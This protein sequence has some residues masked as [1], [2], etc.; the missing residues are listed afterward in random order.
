MSLGKQL[1]TACLLTASFNIFNPVQAMDTLDKSEIVLS[2]SH[3]PRLSSSFSIPKSDESLSVPELQTS[4][5]LDRVDSAITSGISYCLKPFVPIAR[6]VAKPFILFSLFSSQV[7]TAK[8]YKKSHS[9][10]KDC[11]LPDHLR[12][13]ANEYTPYHNLSFLEKKNDVSFLR[14]TKNKKA[15]SRYHKY[16]SHKSRYKT[17]MMVSDFDND[18]I[19]TINEVLKKNKDKTKEFCTEN[20]DK[21]IFWEWLNNQLEMTTIFTSRI[22]A[23]TNSSSELLEKEKKQAYD[24]LDTWCKTSVWSKDYLMG[25]EVETD[26]ILIQEKLDNNIFDFYEKNLS[27]TPLFRFTYDTADDNVVMNGV[28]YRDSEAKTIGGK[29]KEEIEKSAKAIEFLFK[30][31]GEYLRTP[32]EYPFTNNTSG[33]SNGQCKEGKTSDDLDGDLRIHITTQRDI[34]DPYI[35]KL[36]DPKKSEKIFY[37]CLKNSGKIM[38]QVTFQ[39]PINKIYDFVTNYF[40]REDFD[41]HPNIS[42]FFDDSKISKANDKSGARLKYTSQKKQKGFDEYKELKNIE[43][44]KLRGLRTLF[45]FYKQ[46]VFDD[47]ENYRNKIAQEDYNAIFTYLDIKEGGIKSSLTIMSRIAFS[48]MYKLLDINIKE[49]FDEYCQTLDGGLKLISYFD[50]NETNKNLCESWSFPNYQGLCIKDKNNP[51]LKEWCLSIIKPNTRKIGEKLYTTDLLS[52]LFEGHS[53]GSLSLKDS[54]SNALIE[55]RGFNK[56]KKIKTTI[57]SIE[58]DINKEANWFFKKFRGQEFKDKLLHGI[59]TRYANKNQKGTGKVAVSTI[60]G[61]LNR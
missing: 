11:K 48:E 12:Y 41:S 44:L 38:P 3:N 15:N 59:Y 16:K 58:S 50:Y 19:N 8:V 33:K 23:Y 7:D 30:S 29:T 21:K 13:P 20:F 24:I 22:S 53:P 57:D 36:P 25:V 37:A 31:L 28:R 43:D 34:F 14:K 61:F 55:I 47:R 1:L 32:Q 26:Y 56:L 49:K 39:L 45:L 51:S 5:L 27:I 17:S 2:D 35:A 60:K 10:K 18:E 42:Y 40:K 46:W 9:H 52:P 54:D 4:S 6:L